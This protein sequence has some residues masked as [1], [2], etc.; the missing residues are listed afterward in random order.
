M[1]LCKEMNGSREKQRTHVLWDMLSVSFCKRRGE[2]VGIVR[3]GGA[4]PSLK[5]CVKPCSRTGHGRPATGDVSLG[6]RAIL[7]NANIEHGA[8]AGP[9]QQ[10]GVALCGRLRFWLDLT[11]LVLGQGW[12]AHQDSEMRSEGERERRHGGLIVARKSVV[13]LYLRGLRPGKQTCIVSKSEFGTA[14]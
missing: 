10:R 13:I 5:A 3:D 12:R 11:S 6:P 7:A 2:G 14:M 8:D 4:S 9:H 1:S